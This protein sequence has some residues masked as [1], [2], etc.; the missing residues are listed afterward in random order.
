MA[1]DF[2][3]LQLGGGAFSVNSSIPEEFACTVYPTFEEVL[4]LLWTAGRSA[5]MALLDV[6]AAYRHLP[7]APQDFCALVM[8][9]E[10]AFYIEARLPFGVATGPALYNAF[11]AAVEAILISKGVILK[12]MLDDHFLVAPT[13]GGCGEMLQTALD[14]MS[15]LGIQVA[16]HKTVQPTQRA[17]FLGY[18]WCTDVQRVSLDPARWQALA[19]QVEA[20]M[21]A[22]G[23]G[24]VV[25]AQDL[26]E[27]L[28]L[29]VW[30]SRVVELG[31]WQL[32][33][34][35]RVLFRA[36]GN[37]VSARV[38]RGIAVHVT[39]GAL[40]ELGWWAALAQR[41][42]AAG[43]LGVAPGRSFTALRGT[44]PPTI[45]GNT[46]ASSV[47]LGAFWV[48]VAQTTSAGS[49]EWL[50]LFVP[51]AFRANSRWVWMEQG[52]D[53]PA[54]PTL[55]VSSGWLEA[56]AVLAA[57]RCWGP[58]S[59]RGH[60]VLLFCDNQGVVQAWGSQAAHSVVLKALVRAIALE[61]AAWEIML[62]I[63]WL[64]GKK[65]IVAD[66]ISRNQVGELPSP[67]VL[68]STPSWWGLAPASVLTGG[69]SLH[70]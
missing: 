38:A 35:H 7:L 69:L 58:G 39:T 60:S 36:G 37:S 11:G 64:A 13:A 70:C 44:P 56:A 51:P 6:E 12:R 19:A 23:Q 45:V 40:Q 43:E 4:E 15:R 46:D 22:A 21:Q 41:G 26:R 29:L 57:V 34:L 17:K 65:N 8:F 55:R 18:W 27:L 2:R 33:A 50:Q 67:S 9:F 32:A 42:V 10:G 61:C 31:R 48:P 3:P 16:A 63:E 53:D 30:A 54:A 1:H 14:T 66:A 25:S 68:S 28:G 47:A 62:S 59:W 20:L 5:F 24:R 52:P 49:A